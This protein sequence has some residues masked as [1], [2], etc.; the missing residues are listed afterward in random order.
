MSAYEVCLS[1]SQERMLVVVE[2]GM[3]EAARRI[4]DKW[5]LH[6]DEVGR[7]TASGRFMVKEGGKIVADVPADSLVLGGGAPQ[8]RRESQRPAHLDALLNFDPSHLPEPE[9]LNDALLK[10]LSSP[11]IA[12]KRWI[13]EQYDH[14]IGT[15]TRIGGGRSDAAVVRVPGTHIALAMSVDCNARYTAIDPRRGAALAVMEGA[16][17]VAC[18]G[19]TPIGI[20]NCL[21]FGNPMKP[22]NYFFFREAVAG[23]GEACRFLGIPVT[24]GNVSFYNESGGKPVLPT[25][26]IGM[27][28]LLED[29]D[30]A[31]SIGFK[32]EGDFVVL[33]G[34]IGPDL[35][36]SEY[37]SVIHGVFGG[38]P[39]R[40]DLPACKGLVD[41]LG[42]LAS[43]R[44]LQ[45][46]HDLSEGGLAVTLAEK[47]MAGGMGCVLTF[48]WR[49]RIVDNLFAES[50]ACAVVSVTHENW[51]RFKQIVAD[52]GMALQIMGRAGGDQLAIND[53]ISLSVQRME[54]VYEGAIPELMGDGV[55][56][57]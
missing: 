21:N 2:T 5:D 3:E 37:L 8:Y 24:G 6:A 28:G 36:A 26:T 30:D 23:M 25:P 46:A 4:F 57:G 20:T 35:G 42:D 29:V 44:L 54:Q 49:G 33:L 27:I 41:L 7:V 19:G 31:L 16:R 50:S 38:S 18:S 12:S 53:W 11:N 32:E 22:E 17:N 39:P 55:L 1:E 47:C 9:S 13:H 45:S 51:A 34:G 15:N 43:R 52:H 40:L 10:L 56:L 14:T 48:P